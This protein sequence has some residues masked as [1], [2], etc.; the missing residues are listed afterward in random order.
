VAVLGC[1]YSSTAIAVIRCRSGTRTCNEGKSDISLINRQFSDLKLNNERWQLTDSVFWKDIGGGLIAD[2]DLLFG[3]H[4]PILSVLYSP[5]ARLDNWNY[6]YN[7]QGMQ[8]TTSDPLTWTRLLV[9]S[10]VRQISF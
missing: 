2:L 3:I 8:N 6:E 1:T 10:S 9:H 7:Q 4:R 5:S